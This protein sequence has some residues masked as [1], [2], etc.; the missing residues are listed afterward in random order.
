MPGSRRTWTKSRRG[1]ISFPR[2]S[3][4]AP[5]RGGDWCYRAGDFAI[6]GRQG[7]MRDGGCVVALRGDRDGVEVGRGGGGAVVDSRLHDEQKESEERG[8]ALGEGH[9]RAAARERRQNE[10]APLQKPRPGDTGLVLALAGGVDLRAAD[11]YVPWTKCAASRC[12]E[13]FA[14]LPW[15]YRVPRREAWRH[16]GH[17]GARPHRNCTG[18]TTYG[19]HTLGTPQARI[20]RGSW[21]RS[22]QT[23]GR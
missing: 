8:T 10:E 22:R 17:G 23:T 4:R 21:A 16:G 6:W 18:W 19:G 15:C 12:E 20:R 14:A 11:D 7:N 13:V 9:V 3:R 5:A 2:R 1:R